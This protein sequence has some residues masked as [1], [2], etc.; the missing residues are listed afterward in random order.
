MK[1]SIKS[2]WAYRDF[3]LGS[4]NRQLQDKYH[5]SMMG[6]IWIILN[7]LAMVFTYTVIFSKLMNARFIESHSQYAYSIYV[8]SG[9]I[10]WGLFSE[11]VMN[12]QS[13]FLDN[14]ALL[15]KISFPRLCL[16]IIVVFKALINFSIIFGLFIAFLLITKNFPGWILINI[17]PLV[18][19]L[20]IFSIGLGVCLGVLNVFFRDIGQLFGI[21]I[22]FWFWL[23]PIVYS[24][25]ILPGFSRNIITLNPMTPLIQAFQELLLKHLALNWKALLPIIILGIILCMLSFGLFRKHASEIVDE[26]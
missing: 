2:L 7:P 5:N 4:V 19:I 3:I 6:S 16:P 22:N 15:K 10:L 9:L 8:C 24:L 1:A 26:I 11:I 14:A 21:F 17:F 25:D 12:G 23:T 20:V 18:F 13:I